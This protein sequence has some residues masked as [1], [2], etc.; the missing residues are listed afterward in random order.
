MENILNDIR[1]GALPV[2]EMPG[3]LVWWILKNIKNV[4]SGAVI[5]AEMVFLF[6]V[7]S[8]IVPV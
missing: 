4:V 5:G 2:R 3:F 8:G 6:L 1:S 7:I